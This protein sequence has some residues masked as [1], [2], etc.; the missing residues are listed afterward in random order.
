MIYIMIVSIIRFTDK[1][2]A[3]VSKLSRQ[4]H[5]GLKKE[6]SKA[7]KGTGISRPTQEYMDM[8]QIVIDAWDKTRRTL[9][10]KDKPLDSSMGILL[11]GLWDRMNRNQYQNLYATERNVMAAINSYLDCPNN[12]YR[13]EEELLTANHNSKLLTD[14]F[15]MECGIKPSHNLA[16]RLAIQKQNLIL[17]GKVA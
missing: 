1:P 13:T 10:D 9:V 17:E 4:I 6:F 8:N 15:L 11:Q 14:M 16:T 12:E 2:S 3:K 5:K 7:V